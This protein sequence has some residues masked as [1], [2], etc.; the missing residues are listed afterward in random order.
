MPSEMV[1]EIRGS[2]RSG[3]RLRSRRRLCQEER[4]EQ[5]AKQGARG[6]RLEPSDVGRAMRQGANL[7]TQSDA[8][9]ILRAARRTCEGDQPMERAD[10]TPLPARRGEP[11]R[12]VIE[13][14]SSGEGYPPISTQLR[15]RA[16]RSIASSTRCTAKP[17]SNVGRAGSPK[18]RP[19]RKSA[20]D[21]M[22][23]CS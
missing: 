23:V 9:P 12:L 15:S 5:H 13:S 18:S 7:L 10:C 3:T 17:S 20:S 21:L 1:Q 16:E 19:A 2:G 11:R 4:A 8:D 6:E 22:K 14:A